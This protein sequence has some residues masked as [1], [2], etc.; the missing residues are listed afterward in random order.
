M[1]VYSKLEKIKGD[2]MIK[3]SKDFY[4]D[5]T[6]K[7]AKLL[8]GKK[9]VHICSGERVSGR[10]VE[11]EAYKGISDKAAHAYNGRKT[12]RNEMLYGECGIAYVFFIYG[13][14]NCMN[15]VTQKKGE[16]EG[17]LIR[18]LEPCEGNEKMAEFRFKKRYEEL[19]KREVRNLTNGPGKLCTALDIDRKLN[20]A[21]MS[22]SEI[23]IED[24]DFNS[25]KIESSKRINIDYAGEAKDYLLRFYIKGNPY[26]S[27]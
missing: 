11:V 22:G 2:F 9:L 4:A 23:F 12:K 13:M 18:A 1:N 25:F 20:G 3:L 16:P 24:D 15:V 27:K 26:V 10:I 19:S 17:V 21:D 6:T 14:Y 7:V 8:L 5:E